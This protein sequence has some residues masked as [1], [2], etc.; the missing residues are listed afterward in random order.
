MEIAR[1]LLDSKAGVDV[2][3]AKRRTALFYA[4][5]N[6]T[7]DFVNLLLWNGASVIV[8]DDEVTVVIMTLNDMISNNIVLLVCRHV[9]H[10]DCNCCIC[11]SGISGI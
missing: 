4:I 11:D 10:D 1:Y 6:K 5:D 9:P 3:D 7:S 8:G 2:L